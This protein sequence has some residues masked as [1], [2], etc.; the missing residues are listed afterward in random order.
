MS[1]FKKDVL[2]EVGDE[3][4][5][6]IVIGEFGWGRGWG[7]GV[8]EPG[9]GEGGVTLVPWEKRGHCLPVEEALELLNYDY[10]TNFGAPSCHAIYVWTG[11][12]IIWITQ[13]DGSTSLDSAPR[14]PTDVWPEMPGG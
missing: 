11:K 10:D 6:S 12:R 14:N 7:R 5:E 9:F 3:T 2:D 4:I 8:D 1:N 13:Y